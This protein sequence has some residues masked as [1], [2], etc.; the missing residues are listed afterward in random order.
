MHRSPLQLVRPVLRSRA[1]QTTA[2]RLEHFRP[3][4]IARREYTIAASLSALAAFGGGLLY[5]NPPT[6]HCQSEVE[7]E[8]DPPSAFLHATGK[9][10]RKA[11]APIWTRDDVTVVVVIGGPRA[12]KTEQVGRISKAFDMTVE[13]GEQACQLAHED[14]DAD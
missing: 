7:D 4:P 11:G 13:D 1:F 5:L 6:L 10:V 8:V 14:L 9:P 3:P 12:G 2:K